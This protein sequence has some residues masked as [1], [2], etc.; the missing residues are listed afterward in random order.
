MSL[1]FFY[2]CTKCDSYVGCH[3]GTKKPLGILANKEEREL[4]MEC[5]RLFDGIWKQDLKRKYRYFYLAERLG[6]DKND[7]HISCFSKKR[8]LKAIKLM[9]KDISELESE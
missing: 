7:C 3:K 9:K 8:V 4:R 1:N 2:K 6:I 5:H